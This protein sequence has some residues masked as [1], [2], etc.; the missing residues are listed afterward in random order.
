M[1]PVGS[2][3]LAKLLCASPRKSTV[4]S[5]NK[6]NNSD[7]KRTRSPAVCSDKR[8]KVASPKVCKA[9]P[10]TGKNGKMSAPASTKGSP[11]VGKSAASV[12]LSQAVK[13]ASQTLQKSA[14]PK[15]SNG[16]SPKMTKGATPKLPKC[17]SPRMAK[18]ASPK[19]SARSR[20]SSGNLRNK[21]SPKVTSASPQLTAR[22]S[23][24]FA[25]KL[26]EKVTSPRRSTRNTEQS[27]VVGQAQVAKRTDQESAFTPEKTEPVANKT[28]GVKDSAKVVH[29]KVSHPNREVKNSPNVHEKVSHSKGEPKISPKVVHKKV[30][31]P[32]REPIKSPKDG[33]GNVSHP[34]TEAKNSQNVVHE[35][36]SH[37]KSEPTNSPK[38]LHERVSHPK[39]EAKNSPKVV[40]EKAKNSQKIVQEKVSHPKSEPINS[41]KVV[42]GNVSHPENEPK[43]SSKVIHEKVSQSKGE[44]KDL[45][46][47]TQSPRVTR[48]TASVSSQDVSCT[49]EPESSHNA[50]KTN[51]ESEVQAGSS[52]KDNKET[53]TE[54]EQ[55]VVNV[56]ILKDQ[57]TN[58]QVHGRTPTKRNL[59]RRST[60]QKFDAEVTFKSP[61]RKLADSPEFQECSAKCKVML[62]DIK[63]SPL[64][65]EP[66][67]KLEKKETEKKEDSPKDLSSKR[68]TRSN[69]ID[70]EPGNIL[71]LSPI[72]HDIQEPLFDESPPGKHKAFKLR[73]VKTHTVETKYKS[74]KETP[75][76]D[77]GGKS[78]ERKRKLASDSSVESDKELET[79][80]ESSEKQSRSVQNGAKDEGGIQ[81]DTDKKDKRLSKKSRL[82]LKGKNR[83]P[84]LDQ[85]EKI[86]TTPKQSRTS[87]DNTKPVAES[88][89]K[90]AQHKTVE[91]TP[92][93]QSTVKSKVKT[94][95]TPKTDRSEADTS[96]LDTS[97]QS[98][99]NSSQNSSWLADWGGFP[100]SMRLQ[101]KML[102]D[103]EKASSE[104]ALPSSSPA[105]GLKPKFLR[106][107][108]PVPS[109][110][111]RSTKS[112]L[113]TKLK[114]QK[115]AT[116]KKKKS[117]PSLDKKSPSGTFKS[118]GLRRKSPTV[119]N[120]K[121]SPFIVKRSPFTGRPMSVGNI[122]ARARLRQR[123]VP[124]SPLALKSNPAKTTRSKSRE[125]TKDVFNSTGSSDE[126]DGHLHV[127]RQRKS[128]PVKKV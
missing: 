72:Q 36:V 5:H 51:N 47:E 63:Q 50:T 87:T 109:P 1:T 124:Q 32:K 79:P 73:Q 66:C 107:S 59:R 65:G 117:P 88:T 119:T 94:E 101:Q 125:A 95:D 92:K 3:S 114:S 121:K 100:K 2:Q 108:S 98:I 71:P 39:S 89:P 61:P 75:D 20:V 90:S 81:S 15:L 113:A 86:E 60:D 83:T 17:T 58:E 77:N 62:D 82:S 80:A 19:A 78:T 24:R 53:K 43:N 9:S 76:R 103:S 44:S 126:N 46:S 93:Q 68:S 116:K 31:H 29:E 84:K 118:P 111:S 16:A 6:Q 41:P 22:A 120:S 91:T 106:T 112:P 45:V 74:D 104:I 25:S 56:P 99:L 64:N 55:E 7:C 4:A 57:E 34:K 30:S 115:E 35:K 128:T 37:P 54:S 122:G 69:S 123:A 127:R 49:K 14:S 105:W 21:Q 102:E 10:K 33:R 40:H 18:G 12:A 13:K 110:G 23:P 67:P 48:L 11:L 42:H 27:P 96:R 28:S 52:T 97:S 38:I 85:T 8:Q 26:E 70:L